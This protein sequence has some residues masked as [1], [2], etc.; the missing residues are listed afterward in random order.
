MGRKSLDVPR[1]Q[2]DFGVGLRAAV[3]RHRP[4]RSLRG[5]DAV[6]KTDSGD[7]AREDEERNPCG[8]HFVGE[9]DRR[10]VHGGAHVGVVVLLA[11]IDGGGEV[12]DRVEA[13]ERVNAREIATHDLDAS[14]REA[15]RSGR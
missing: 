15:A 4:P 9:A 13:L 10:V 3:G 5:D 12:D 14:L 7:G 11:R 2:G 8:A 1:N 6:V